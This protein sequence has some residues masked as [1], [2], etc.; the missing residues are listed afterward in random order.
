MFKDTPAFSSFSV[1]DIE[2]AKKFY[3]E[4]LGLE[5]KQRPEGLELHLAGGAE[6][7]IYP[8]STYEVP[9]HTVLMFMVDDIHAAIQELKEKGIAMEQYDRPDFTTDEEGVLENDGTH[10][11]PKAVAWFKDPAGHVLS[12]IQE[13]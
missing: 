12:I 2:A 9:T 4:T 3:G 13:K 1:D 5:V 8:S 11:G 10:P 7:F 6:V